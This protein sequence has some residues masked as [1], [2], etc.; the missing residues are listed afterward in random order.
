MLDSTFMILLLRSIFA[1][2]VQ[3]GLILMELL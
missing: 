1:G 3:P 2:T